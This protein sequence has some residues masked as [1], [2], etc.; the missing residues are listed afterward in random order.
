VRVL[1]SLNWTKFW[2][3]FVQSPDAAPNVD[4]GTDLPLGDK[5]AAAFVRLQEGLSVRRHSHLSLPKWRQTFFSVLVQIHDIPNSNP[6]SGAECHCDA[7]SIRANYS[8]P[9]CRGNK[10][11]PWRDSDGHANDID[12]LRR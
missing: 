4:C 11:L 2:Y 5:R 6:R 3:L 8:E 1:S 10:R 7:D 9:K 12:R